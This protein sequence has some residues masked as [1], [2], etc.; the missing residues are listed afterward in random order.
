MVNGENCPECGSRNTG[1][2]ELAYTCENESRVS[3]DWT[4]DDCGCSYAVLY[5]KDEIN[6]YERNWGE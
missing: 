5:K 6:I 4:C 2:G 1:D 3:A